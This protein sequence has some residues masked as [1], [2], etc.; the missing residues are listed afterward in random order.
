VETFGGF[1]TGGLERLRRVDAPA[2]SVSGGSNTDQRP[3]VD[4][5]WRPA[6]KKLRLSV[7]LD[8]SLKN[9]KIT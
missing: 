6:V 2:T 1:A 8:N 5:E 3:E 4:L 9:V 7:I